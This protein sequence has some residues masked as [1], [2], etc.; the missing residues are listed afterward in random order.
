MMTPGPWSVGDAVQTRVYGADEDTVADCSSPAD[1]RAIA[2]LPECL[3]SM[4]RFIYSDRASCRDPEGD[5]ERAGRVV[6]K[7]GNAM[8]VPC[9]VRAALRKAG[10]L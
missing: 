3:A 7:I 6:G 8:C 5:C 9:E 10:V 2:A 4:L 1:A